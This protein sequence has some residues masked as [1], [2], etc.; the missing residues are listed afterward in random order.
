MS[1]TVKRYLD[2][3]IKIGIRRQKSNRY[4]MNNLF[5]I[6]REYNNL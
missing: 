3:W 4:L 5:S 2:I 6:F 1:F